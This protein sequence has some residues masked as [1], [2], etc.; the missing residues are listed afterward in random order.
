MNHHRL[1]EDSE[2]PLYSLELIF[3]TSSTLFSQ[4]L[5]EG[6]AT[7]D[8]MVR[9]IPK[10]R[11][12]LLAGGLEAIIQYISEL[13]F[14]EDQ[15]KYLLEAK[16]VS[17]SFAEYLRK[18]KFTGSILA[19]PE[20]TLH[21]PSEPMLR[22]TAPL[23]EAN[24]ITDLLI[25]LS[26]IDTLL[27]SK[28][29]RLHIA[30]DGRAAIA[31]GTIRAQGV[32]AG[33]RAC[34][35]A[36]FFEGMRFSNAAASMRLGVEAATPIMVGNHAFIKAFPSEFEAMRAFTA[37][38][39]TATPMIDTYDVRMGIANAI[40]IADELK[41]SG[42]ELFAVCI[43]SGDVAETAHYAREQLDRAG[44]RDTKIAIAGNMDEYKIKKILDDGVPVQAFLVVTEVVTSADE[45]KLEMV[46]KLAQLEYRGEIKQKAKFADGKASLPGVKQ[47]YRTVK[48]GQIAGDIIGLE[49]EN[50][51]LPLLVPVFKGGKLVYQMPSPEERRAYVEEQLSLLPVA[52]R[53]L[54]TPQEP[55]VSVSKGVGDLVEQV[56]AEHVTP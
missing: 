26:H 13:H 46:Y 2:L 3:A 25:H 51:G 30:A 27:L 50:L 9:D 28:L 21:F 23:V 47:V 39:P 49:G 5:H 16:R 4:G 53:D 43:D 20:G 36:T 32:D 33:W 12:F 15:V 54:T 11:N 41:T 48:S 10:H 1:I 14:S 18:F 24:L 56:R 55:L 17:S 22:V 35:A 34:R 38:V 44:H 6:V 19:M 42:R 29:A 8:L 52:H 40:T 45:P 7:Y 31:V 37:E